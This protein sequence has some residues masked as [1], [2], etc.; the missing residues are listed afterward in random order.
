MK[1]IEEKVCPDCGGL[2]SV[3]INTELIE[4]L[5]SALL[6]GETLSTAQLEFLST[7]PT[8]KICDC[9]IPMSPVLNWPNRNQL[10][11]ILIPD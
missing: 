5:L 8:Q 4:K 1:S 9:H 2:V 11:V 3:F 7:Q 10:K 6:A